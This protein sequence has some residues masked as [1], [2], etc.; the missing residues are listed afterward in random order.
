ML[1]KKYLKP[2]LSIMLAAFLLLTSL[3]CDERTPVSSPPPQLSYELQL[4][5]ND[6]ECSNVTAYA[7]NNALGEIEITAQLSI[8]NDEDGVMDGGHEGQN[9]VFSWIKDDGTPADG[10]FQISEGYLP[11]S[12]D[13]TN[14]GLT[15]VNGVVKGVWQDESDLGNFEVKAIYTDQ[16]DVSVEETVS[17][18]LVSPESLIN[19]VVGYTSATNNTLEV[20]DNNIY[21]TNI[22]A[23]VLNE[24]GVN[25][26][27]IDVN[28]TKVSGSGSLSSDT[29]KTGSDGVASVEYQTAPGTSDDI[30]SFSVT[31]DGPEDCGTDCT[32]TFQLT[33]TSE[34]FPQEYYVRAFNLESNLFQDN[35]SDGVKDLLLLDSAPDSTYTIIFE[36]TTQDSANIGVPNV[37]VYYRNLSDDSGDSYGTIVTSMPA[38]TNDGALEPSLLGVAQAELVINRSDIPLGYGRIQIE[39]SIH[40]PDDFNDILV[41][42]ENG[43]QALGTVSVDVLTEQYAI[44]EAIDDLLISTNQTESFENNNSITYETVITARTID[45]FGGLVTDPVAIN[46]QK[47]T[48]D[49]GGYLSSTSVLTDSTGKAESTFIVNSS[50]FDS[51]GPANIDFNVF[52]AQDSQ[53]SENLTLSYYIEGNQDPELDVAEF[54]F[55]PDS[56]TI[57]HAL[58]EQ[59]NISIIAKNDAG[60]GISNVLVRFDLDEAT[61]NSFGELSNGYEYTCC[62]QVDDGSSGSEGDETYSCDDGSG[63]DPEGDPCPDGSSCS[64][65]GS[66]GTGTGGGQNGVASVTYTNISEGIDELR[67]YVLNP[68]NAS[69]VLFEDVIYINS[70]P[71]C[72]D[73]SEQ[74]TLVSEKYTLP[75]SN[76]LESTNIY[77]FYTDSLGNQPDINDI[78]SFEAI[79]FNDEDEWVDIGS[80]TPEYSFFEE[81]D[82]DD[83]Q[84]YLPESFDIEGSSI[85]YAQATFNMENSSGLARIVGTYQ[86]ISDTLGIQINSTEAS[87]VE[88]L[89]PF[90]SEIIVQGGGGQESTILTAEIRDGNGNLVSDPYLVRFEVTPPTLD[91]IHLNGIPG[92]IDE[93][94][95]SSNGSASITL[96]SGTKPGS[97]HMRVTVTDHPENDNYDPTFEIVAE[98]TPVTITTGP[99]TSAVIGYAFGEAINIGGGLTEMPVSIMLWDAWSNPVSDSTAVYFSLNPPTAA[100][101]IA[102]AKTGN[103]KPN[104]GDEEAWPGVAWTTT[105]YN[106]A[107]LFEF[108]EI[109]AQTTGNV[110]LNTN[111]TN[112]GDCEAQEMVWLPVNSETDGLCSMPTGTNPEVC[113]A[114]DY[115]CE[116]LFLDCDAAAVT[117]FG[118]DPDGDGIYW[119]IALPLTFSSLD[120]IV[121]YENVCVDCTLSLV[122]LSDTQ[123]DFNDCAG[124]FAPPDF[125]VEL[126]AQL[127][128]SYN[129]PVEGALVEL[130]IFDSQGGPTREGGGCTENDPET[131]VPFTTQQDCLDAGGEWGYG[132]WIDEL[133]VYGGTAIA[134][135]EDGLKYFNVTFTIDECIQTS[136]DPE[137]WTCSSPII[138][139][140]LLNPNGGTSEQINITLNNTCAN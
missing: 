105:Q 127:L 55:Y 103:V 131:G 53:V 118:N 52:L 26:P 109:I 77:A 56:D 59:T 23:R 92:D 80:I 49:I 11:S 50:D 100:A 24:Q 12:G 78:I 82:I 32:D 83:I 75:D 76:N 67:A 1:E 17:I 104:S 114:E 99:P 57:S 30:V 87:F 63:C 71:N 86:G 4:F 5:C 117:G 66:G 7:A 97:V 10:Y 25:L 43:T 126:R 135:D 28:F 73:C 20:P 8:D 112:R 96:N 54:H 113:D 39:A 128:D 33:I 124:G 134:T 121:S 27:N 18:T 95:I 74:L 72:P 31:V 3:S 16:Y 106:S 45:S 123:F 9:I 19:S 21:T 130:I 133:A 65:D 22:N 6:A 108:P 110:C 2:I 125:E 140:N 90:P 120:N 122:P 89:P 61:R 38:Y 119:G 138:Q 41:I 84:E 136:D 94:E 47:L 85:V 60:V 35:N 101:I 46:F 29:A 40:D 48:P 102:E 51:N 81:G 36:V 42:D 88:I 93:T 70:V 79:Q 137:Q 13:A 15:N 139:A 34:I 62:G 115:N 58:F 116:A 14:I 98:S 37:P 68:N 69:E 107:Q 129:V 44:I 64:A 111:F 91:G 132:N